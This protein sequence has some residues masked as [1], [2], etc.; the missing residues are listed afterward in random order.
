MQVLTSRL[1]VTYITTQGSEFIMYYTA[2]IAN[3]STH[4]VGAATATNPAGPYT[5]QETTIACPAYEGGAIDPAGFA[6]DNGDLYV[7]Y[8]IDA[9]SLGNGGNC[10]NGVP[11]IKTTPIMLQPL[12]SDGLTAKGSPTQILDN[13][14]EDGPLVEAP[15]LVKVSGTYYLFYSRN[16]YAGPWYVVAHATAAS[17]HGPYTKALNPSIATGFGP[18]GELYAPG[19]ATVV[20]Q[21]DKMVFHADLGLNSTIRQMYVGFPMIGGGKVII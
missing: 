14:I 4:C 21:G 7:V 15:S 9:N 18:I 12:E 1:P 5:P 17:I 8:K 2:T 10:N 11:P 16:C 20:P 13:G 6:D 19:G 3:G